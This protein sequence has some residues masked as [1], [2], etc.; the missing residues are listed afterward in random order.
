MFFISTYIYIYIY[1][2]YIKQFPCGYM[3]M[4]CIH[5]FMNISARALPSYT[6]NTMYMWLNMQL[7]SDHLILSCWK[8][9]TSMLRLLHMPCSTNISGF[10]SRVVEHF[11]ISLLQSDDDVAT[12]LNILWYISG[13]NYVHTL[14]ILF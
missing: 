7:F 5:L 14:G 12:C 4:T 3:E 10:S 13:Q 9:S 6:D 8:R 2:C 11:I 1:I